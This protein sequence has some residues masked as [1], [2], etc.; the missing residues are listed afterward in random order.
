MVPSASTYKFLSDV[1]LFWY[2]VRQTGWPTGRENL[3]NAW[4]DWES[5][6]VGT[7]FAPLYLGAIHLS[8]SPERCVTLVGHLFLARSDSTPERCRLTSHLHR[9]SPAV[10][11]PN[12]W[13]YSS[14]LIHTLTPASVG[15]VLGNKY[16]DWRVEIPG[17]S[18]LAF[19]VSD[20]HCNVCARSR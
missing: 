4:S 10:E 2:T 11:V 8:G 9:L 1:H 12:Q 6:V 19:C 15:K 3:R 5:I 14:L 18:T 13:V 7:Q 20:C 17:R 16:S